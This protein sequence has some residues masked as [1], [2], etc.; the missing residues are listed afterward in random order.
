MS[1]AGFQNKSSR[2]SSRQVSQGRTGAAMVEAEPVAGSAAIPMW[3]IGALGL[4]LYIG[5]IYVADHGGFNGNNFDSRIYYPY[6][7]LAEVENHQPK[8]DLPEGYVLGRS[9]YGIGCAPCHGPEGQ[10]NPGT[11]VP[12]LAGSEWVNAAKPDRLTRIVLDGP[13]GSIDVAGKTYSNEGMPPWRPSSQSVG[14]SDEEIAGVLTYI[15]NTWGNNAPPVT[16]AEV[17]EI[18]KATADHHD[19]RWT[20]DELKQIP[21]K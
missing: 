15:R 13:T 1:A 5:D 7:S 20:A 2:P 9:K 19:K 3:L 8:L 14:M 18:H 6:A 17:A 21:E 4:L 16:T 10:G 11:L 12:P